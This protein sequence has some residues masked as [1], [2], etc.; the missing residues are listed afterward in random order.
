MDMLYTSSLLLALIAGGVGLVLGIATS[1]VRG[2]VSSLPNW[3]LFALAISAL[4]LAVSISAHFIWGHG[5]SSAEPMRFVRFVE[6]HP[7]LLVAA[8]IIAVGLVVAFQSL[9]AKS[10]D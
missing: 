3:A 4:A 2:S 9:R 5:S 10:Q 6:L 1:R 8:I 7:A